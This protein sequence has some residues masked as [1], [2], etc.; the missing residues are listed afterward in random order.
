LLH[1]PA[2]ALPVTGVVPGG[3]SAF[4]QAFTLVGKHELVV[5]PVNLLH[6]KSNF[7]LGLEQIA[8][9]KAVGIVPERALRFSFNVLSVD[10]SCWRLAPAR[11]PLRELTDRSKEINSA[12]LESEFGGILPLRE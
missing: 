11:V 12:K 5:G 7:S 2:G 6:W 8:V 1:C 10:E 4:G 9:A 3:Q